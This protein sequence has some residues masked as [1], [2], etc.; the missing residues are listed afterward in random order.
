MRQLSKSQKLFTKYEI[1]QAVNQ[2]SAVT[3][4]ILFPLRHPNA[5]WRKSTSRIAA[6]TSHAIASGLHLPG[7]MLTPP[8]ARSQH[9]IGA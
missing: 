8:L 5:E 1:M 7:T 6:A 9:F 3:A 2:H 4:A